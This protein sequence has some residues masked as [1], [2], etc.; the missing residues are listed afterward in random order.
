MNMHADENS[1]GVI[2]QGRIRAYDLKLSGGS[3]QTAIGVAVSRRCD[4]LVAVVHGKGAPLELQRAA[5]DFL[6]TSKMTG[7]MMVAMEGR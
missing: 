1:D 2:V 5:L 4:L 6:A 7:W 3:Q